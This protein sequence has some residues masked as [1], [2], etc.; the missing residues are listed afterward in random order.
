[1]LQLINIPSQIYNDTMDND[2][3]NPKSVNILPRTVNCE[4]QFKFFDTM[5]YIAC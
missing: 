5:L 4:R 2:V 3:N 1:M